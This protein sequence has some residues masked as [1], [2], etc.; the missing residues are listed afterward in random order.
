MATLHYFAAATLAA[1]SYVIHQLATLGAA[2]S[3]QQQAIDELTT[4]VEHVYEEVT[5]AAAALTARLDE[6]QAQIDNGV[7]ATDLDLTALAAGIQKLDDLTPD[8]PSE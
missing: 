4:K 5:S 7:P 1:L 8:A 6:L 3:D 2:M